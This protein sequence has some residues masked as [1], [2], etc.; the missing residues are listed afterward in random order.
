MVKYLGLADL[1]VGQLIKCLPVYDAAGTGQA[2]QSD[3]LIDVPCIEPPL[4]HIGTEQGGPLKPGLKR[5]SALLLQLLQIK[6]RRIAPEGH[7]LLILPARGKLLHTDLFKA[8]PVI[9]TI[10]PEQ[11]GLQ[12]L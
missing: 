4:P 6:Q 2:S 9:D 10:E 11:M 3:S 1:I 7:K 8:F 5:P 12:L